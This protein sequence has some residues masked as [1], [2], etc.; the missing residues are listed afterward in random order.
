MTLPLQAR[1]EERTF[2][3]KQ[4]AGTSRG[5]YRTR[6]SWFITL[7]D[8]DGRKGI[9]ECAPLP[10]L[11]CDDIPNY[12]EV[13]A[14]HCRTLEQTGEIPFEALRPHPSMLFGM[15]TAMLHL[16][17]GGLQ[18]Y[19]TPWSRGEEGIPINGLVWMGTKEEMQ[20]RLIEKIEAGFSC[21]KLKIGVDLD[22]EL[23]LLEYVRC[24]FGRGEV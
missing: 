4:P 8:K 16:K 10:N 3:F 13:L 12:A 7:T 1:I 6:K 11:S 22:G 24:R 21:I 19:D 17:S 18:F 15:E 9:G 23:E 2:H 20:E 14:R 5:V